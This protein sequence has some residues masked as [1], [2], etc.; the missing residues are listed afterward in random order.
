MSMTPK[1]SVSPAASRNSINP[2]WRPFSACSK[3]KMPLTRSSTH[4]RHREEREQRGVSTL[5]CA[6]IPRRCLGMTSSLHRALL[7]VGVAVIFEDRVGE[8]LVDQSALAIGANGTHVVVLDRILIGV[9]AESAA[10]RIELSV[11]QRL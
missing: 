7:H 3:M 2:N 6:E 4:A 10:H 1:I 9:E 11:L 5:R 8:R